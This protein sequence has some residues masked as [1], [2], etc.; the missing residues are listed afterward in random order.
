MHIPLKLR[1]GAQQSFP[2]ALFTATSIFNHFIS[3]FHL[4][5]FHFIQTKY[6]L[7]GIYILPAA[8]TRKRRNILN[9]STFV[10]IK[11]VCWNCSYLKMKCWCWFFLLF[12]SLYNNIMVAATGNFK[13]DAISV[14]HVLIITLNTFIS[15]F[16]AKL[17]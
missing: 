3:Q 12:T 10:S 13:F 11:F 7:I 6:T 15:F 2:S 4:I 1:L 17:K 9:L 16:I 14:S 8:M 5:S